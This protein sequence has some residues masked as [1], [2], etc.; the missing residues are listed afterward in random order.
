[1]KAVRESGAFGPGDA[2]QVRV[3]IGWGGEMSLKV[4]TCASLLSQK[5]TTDLLRSQLTRLDFVLRETL[6]FRHPIP[7]QPNHTQ[8][9]TPRIT[10]IFTANASVSSDPVCSPSART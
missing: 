1:M 4:C 9:S 10:S 8:R 7:G 3:Q 5:P 6:T 2:V